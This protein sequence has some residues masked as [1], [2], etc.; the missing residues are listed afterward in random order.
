MGFSVSGATAV[1]FV[2][3]LVGAATLY[4]AVDRYAERRSDAMD[5]DNERILTQQNTAIET[6]NTTYNASTEEL[7]I[8]VQNT[9]ASTLSVSETDVLVDGGYVQSSARNSTVDGSATTDI[10]A[11]GQTL[12]VTLTASTEPNRV[13]VVSGPGVAI[14]T[15]VEVR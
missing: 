9:G 8:T 3:L 10:W 11:P 12:T 2:G 1:L 6:V 14:T 15:A 4:P 5:A 13:K 7:Q